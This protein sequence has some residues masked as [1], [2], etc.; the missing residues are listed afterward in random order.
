MNIPADYATARQRFRDVTARLGWIRHAYPVAA[1]LN[2]DLT[3]DVALSSSTSADA[4]LV[5]S[6]GLHGVEGA[7]GSAVQGP[8]GAVGGRG[9]GLF[10]AFSCTRCSVAGF[11]APARDADNVD[12]NRNFLAAR[13]I[14]AAPTHGSIRCQPPDPTSH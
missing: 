10:D 13:R 6:S 4:V 14:S 7:F 12:L 9:S 3:I 5:V 8:V 11:A 1:S 2:G